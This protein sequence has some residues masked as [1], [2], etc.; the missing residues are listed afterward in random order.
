MNKVWGPR[1]LNLAVVEVLQRK[2]PLADDDLLDE[3]KDNYGELSFRE[4][5]SALLKLELNGVLR[6]TRLMKGKRRVELVSIKSMRRLGI[7]LPEKIIKNQIR[8]ATFHSPSGQTLRLERRTPITWVLDRRA[9]DEH[10]ANRASKA[11]AEILLNCRALSMRT[12]EPTTVEVRVSSKEKPGTIRG[13]VV[14]GSL[15]AHH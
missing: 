4:L 15:G 7:Q 8:G 12:T 3:V 13:N 5:N 6:V 1:P 14:V 2:G 10:L 11:G 9:F